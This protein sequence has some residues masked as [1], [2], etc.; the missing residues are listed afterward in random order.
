MLEQYIRLRTA[1]PEGKTGEAVEMTLDEVAD[2]LCCTRRNATLTLKKMQQ[3][4]WLAWQP[5]RGRGNRST[6]ICYLE[7]ADL[8]LSTA[9]ELVQKGEIRSSRELVDRYRDMWPDAAMEYTR[10]MNSHFGVHTGK[11]G[12]KTKADTLRLFVDRPFEGLDPIHVLL[13]SQMHISK[14][15]FDTLVRFDTE[16]RRIEPHLVYAWEKDADGLVWT[17]Y[18]RKGVLFHHGRS[19]VADDVCFSLERLRKGASPHRWLLSSVEHVRAIDDYVVQI[20][21]RERNELLLP[22][23]SKEYAGIVP[24]DYVEQMGEQFAL[25]P[26]GTGGFRLIR[27]DDSMLVLEA[28][29]PY[30]AGR[31]FV[32]RVEL[33]CLPDLAADGN[34]QRAQLVLPVP[35]GVHG[36]EKMRVPENM[37]VSEKMAVPVDMP[38]PEAMHAPSSNDTQGI[39]NLSW[40]RVSRTEECFQYASLNAAKRGPLRH[41]AF[42]KLIVELIHGDNMRSELGGPRER[43]EVWGESLSASGESRKPEETKKLLQECGYSGETLLL[44]TYPDADH[45]E[46]AEWI[47]NTC[48]ECGIGVEIVYTAPDEL[49]KPDAIRQADIIVDSANLDERSEVSLME[50]LCAEALSVRH[51]MD[52][53]LREFVSDQ[54]KSMQQED[55]RERREEYAAAIIRALFCEGVLVPLY[56]NRV[57][58]YTHPLVKNVRLDAYGWIDYSR[59]LFRI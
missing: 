3:R 33:W 32:D 8:M 56:S 1:K 17:F 27:N 20:C 16:T 14:Q 18:L 51:H 43:A 26:S 6:L 2:K 58:M 30:F 12:G 40:E 7:P 4:G 5:G 35:V 54:M 19:L 46:D 24:R 15:I 47:R 11:H 48:H 55:D 59:L 52:S 42:R 39:R 37:Y 45:A 57:D 44:Y 50:L 49:A 22:L 28:F 31:P 53:R 36:S 34:P 41:P 9:K 38:L 29:D 23:L 13:R 25:M 21:L 10:W